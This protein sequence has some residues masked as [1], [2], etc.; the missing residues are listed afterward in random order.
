MADTAAAKTELGHAPQFTI[1][2][3]LKKTLDWYKTSLS[4][5]ASV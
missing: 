1:E 5:K 4:A 3:G 2:S